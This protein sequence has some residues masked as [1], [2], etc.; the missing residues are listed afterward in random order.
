MAD[1][2]TD[3]LIG[4]LLA[5]HWLI[6]WLIALHWLIGWLI[7]LHSLIG[8]LCPYSV[9]SVCYHVDTGRGKITANNRLR[10]VIY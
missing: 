9:V 1:C 8:M 10:A 6:G 4:W 7:A 2:L 5:L 3:D